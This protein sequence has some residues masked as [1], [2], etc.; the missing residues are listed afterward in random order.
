MD[1]IDSTASLPVFTARDMNEKRAEIRQAVEDEGCIIQYKSSGRRVEL[2][3]VLVEKTFYDLLL[4][5]Y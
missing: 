2:E 3:A 5:V 4:S 1:R